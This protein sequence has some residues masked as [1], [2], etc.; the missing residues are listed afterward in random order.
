MAPVNSLLIESKLRSAGSSGVQIP[1]GPLTS[2]RG[3]K[4]PATFVRRTRKDLQGSP[5]IS[6]KMGE[7]SGLVL[8]EIPLLSAKDKETTALIL[9]KFEMRKTRLQFRR[10]EE[11]RKGREAFL[12]ATGSR[13]DYMDEQARLFADIHFLL[14]CLK[15]LR[16]LFLKMQKY[17]PEDVKLKELEDRYGKLLDHCGDFRNDLEHIEDRPG[18]GVI[19]LG[20]TFGSVFQFGDR[21]LNLDNEFETKIRSFY[22]EVESVYDGIL[23]RRRKES[24][25]PLVMLS[26]RVTVPGPPPPPQD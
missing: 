26:G 11:D 21:Q 2:I 12:A 17:F 13:S 3:S 9:F 8:A 10:I 23:L 15:K 24:G 1:F 4:G 16:S 25:E 6:S 22:S 19:G 18:E 5:I 7:G 14:V 20:S